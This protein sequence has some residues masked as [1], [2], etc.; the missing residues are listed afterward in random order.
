MANI[1]SSRKDIRRIAKL[2]EHNR[3]VRSRLKTLNKNVEKAAQ[4]GDAAEAKAAAQAFVSALDKAAKRDIIH[5]NKAR[6][7]QQAVS[8]HIFAAS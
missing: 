5:P 2:T 3:Q 8:K 7:H 6:R 1:Q 4:T